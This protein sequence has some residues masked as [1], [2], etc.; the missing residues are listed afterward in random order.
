MTS[1]DVTIRDECLFC[2][3]VSEMDRINR[4]KKVETDEKSSNC[5]TGYLL[6]LNKNYEK[7]TKDDSI[8]T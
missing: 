8:K 7:M 5:Y 2:G 6:K 4:E 1:I 3:V